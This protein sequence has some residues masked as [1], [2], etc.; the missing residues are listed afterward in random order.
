VLAPEKQIEVYQRPEDGQ[1]TERTIH[2]PGGRLASESVPAF[3]VE[4]SN[5]FGS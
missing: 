5:L 2:G 1:F 4:L 3:T